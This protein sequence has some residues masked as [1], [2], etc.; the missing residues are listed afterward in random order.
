MIMSRA[1]TLKDHPRSRG[2]YGCRWLSPPR[3][4]GIIPARAGFT[5]GA[6]LHGRPGRDHPRSRGVYMHPRLSVLRITG[7]SPLA[8][9]LLAEYLKH[10]SD[11]RI[12]PAR[13]GFTDL[14]AHPVVAGG[15]HPRSRGVYAPARTPGAA[16]GGSSPL[17]RGLH[18]RGL[19]LPERVRIIPARAG[20]TIGMMTRAGGSRIIPARAGF[21]RMIPS[22]LACF[23]GS[24]PLARGL[25][26]THDS[27]HTNS[28]II[29]ARAGFTRRYPCAG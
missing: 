15:D 19:D 17:A 26:K 10:Y 16:A 7:S 1:A 22:L 14:V 13:A 27:P 4:S 3:R 8:R 28:R 20:F 18:A 12:I 5:D 29:P 23:T 6:L 21:T 9:G 25:L 11:G 2:V 24:S